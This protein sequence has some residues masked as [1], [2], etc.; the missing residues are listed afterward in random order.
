MKLSSSVTIDPTTSWLVK[1]FDM[2]LTVLFGDTKPP[3]LEEEGSL[4][5]TGSCFTIFESNLD[6]LESVLPCLLMAALPGLAPVEAVLADFEA[7]AL[8]LWTRLLE[9]EADLGITPNTDGTLFSI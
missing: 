9:F 1:S 7:A 5:S 4:I 8:T 2:F 6:F 3:E